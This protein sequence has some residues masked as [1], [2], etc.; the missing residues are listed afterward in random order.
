MEFSEY[1][2]L[3]PTT[4]VKDKPWQLLWTDVLHLGV[5]IKKKQNKKKRGFYVCKRL[6]DKNE[7]GAQNHHC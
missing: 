1:F 4:E 2:R 6:K 7:V 5:F 3:V